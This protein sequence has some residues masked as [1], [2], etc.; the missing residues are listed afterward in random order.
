MSLM[1]KGTSGTFEQA[2][3]GTFPARCVRIID[4][5]TQMTSGQFAKLTPQ[6]MLS[7]QLLGEE[8]MSDGQPFLINQTYTMSLNE[9][10][11]LRKMLQTWRG[12]PFTDDE[13][14]GFDLGKVLGLPCLLTVVHNVSHTNGNTYANVQAVAAPMKGMTI[15][16][17]TVPLLAYDIDDDSP[18]IFS[19]LP[20]FWQSRIM[21]SQEKSGGTPAPTPANPADPTGMFDEEEGDSIPF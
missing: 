12:R 20:E 4:L 10:A 5:G 16:E 2:P 15:E 3:A 11:N 6:V 21:Q 1:A 17:A 7:W 9:K 13:L 19:Q 8:R 14:K 18:E